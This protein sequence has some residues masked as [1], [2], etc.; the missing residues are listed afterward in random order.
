[1]RNLEFSGGAADVA[2]AKQ[3]KGKIR[4]SETELRQL[5]DLTPMH[6]TE[7]GPD[8][9]PLFNNRAAL[10]YHGL[11]LEQW[12]SADLHDLVH[13]QDAERLTREHPGK[14]RSGSPYESAVR[15][16]SRFA[17]YLPLVE[18]SWSHP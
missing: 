4:Q 15:Q 13:P 12:R 18:T 17:I 3:A 14:F 7:F 9:S 16:G 1:L 8:G 11:T 6:I 5:L 10:D 2:A